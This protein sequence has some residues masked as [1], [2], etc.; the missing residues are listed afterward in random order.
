M[1]MTLETLLKCH[2]LDRDMLE[3]GVRELDAKP[4]ET[5]G[6]RDKLE[7]MARIFL[8]MVT[9]NPKLFLS[10]DNIIKANKREFARFVAEARAAGF[11]GDPWLDE[12]AIEDAIKFPHQ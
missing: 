10:H 5:M 9:A 7:L 12:Q 8:A 1:T 2:G 11:K 3:A 4:I 6:D